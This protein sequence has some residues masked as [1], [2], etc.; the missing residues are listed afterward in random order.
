MSDPLPAVEVMA[1]EKYISHLL[2]CSECYAPK[3]RHCLAGQLLRIEYDAQF[4]MTVTDLRRR[5][6]L[7]CLEVVQCPENADGLKDR[8]IELFNE[9]S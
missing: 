6:D 3:K 5:R 8:V 2:F 1:H 4:L 9:Q 7:L